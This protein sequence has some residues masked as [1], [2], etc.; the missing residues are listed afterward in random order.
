[1]VTP[2]F[3]TTKFILSKA[4]LYFNTIL[5]SQSVDLF[6]KQKKK[7]LFQT[8]VFFYREKCYLHTIR[9][10]QTQTRDK[11]EEHL[12]YLKSID[13]TQP[14][15]RGVDYYRSLAINTMGEFK[16]IT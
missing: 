14:L 6:T 1:M 4:H 11:Q 10:E 3:V 13:R 9:K 8:S 7:Q 5:G 2:S 12:L 15:L 16:L